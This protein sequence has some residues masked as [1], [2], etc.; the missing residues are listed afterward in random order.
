MM[1]K[2]LLFTLATLFLQAD[3][4]PQNVLSKNCLESY[5]NSYLSQKDHKAFIYAREEETGKDKC[6]WGYGYATTEEAIDSAMK[7]CQSVLLNAECTLVDT[8]GVFKVKEGTFSRLTPVD[9]TPLSTEEKEKILQQSK[10]LILGNCLPFFRDKY[11][12]APGHKSFAYSVDA[13]GHYACGYASGQMIQKNSNKEAIKACR[14]N[15]DKRGDAAPKSPCKIY[16]YD[17]QILLD[18]KDFDIDLHA[19]KKITLDKEAFEKKLAKAKEIIGNNACL[20]QMKY[21]LR[22]KTQQAYYFA[23]SIDK[24][25]CGRKEGAFSLDEAKKEAQKSCEK[26]AKAQGIKQPCK[27]L[28]EN[29]KIVGKLS[30]FSVVQ[31]ISKK[32]EPE[33]SKSQDVKKDTKPKENMSASVPVA[34]AL[35][36]AAKTLNKGLPK[37]TDSETRLEK[38]TAQKKKMIYDL[39]LVHFTNWSMPFMKLKSLLYKDLKTQ[40][41]SDEESQMLLKKGVSISYRYSDKDARPIGTFDFD[42]KTCGLTTNLERIKRNILHMIK[43]K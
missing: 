31:L 40:V 43:K 13:N 33:V 25:A 9:D 6:N 3:M 12:D 15:K 10:G 2:L 11:L 18:A 24:Q 39:T 26:M 17:K 5:Q 14:R 22:G 23:K 38:V 32:L 30:D 41:C 19:K 27:L 35:D 1:Y 36:M 28:A 16:A 7:G 8:D 20:M 37:M 29:D 42:A 4:L 34:K 21:Y